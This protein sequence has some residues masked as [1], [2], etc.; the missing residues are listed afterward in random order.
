M[1]TAGLTVI[2]LPPLFLQSVNESGSRIQFKSQTKLK[3]WQMQS[4]A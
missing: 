2:V 1:L 3:N 4:V